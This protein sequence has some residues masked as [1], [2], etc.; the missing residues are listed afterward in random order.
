MAVIILASGCFDPLHYGHLLHLK[1]AKALGGEL[2]VAV[3]IDENVN[4]GPGRPVFKAHQR[5]EMVGELRCVD[6]VLIVSS[7]PDAIEHIR[8]DI[9]VKGKE[10]DRHP[11]IPE[12]SLVRDYGGRVVYLD[13]PKLSSTALLR[14]YYDRARQGKDAQDFDG[15]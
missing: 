8:P 9:F 12:E 1:A 6:C 5:A 15:R 14:H 2:W 10:Y 4:K 11:R 3:T 7:G 13:T